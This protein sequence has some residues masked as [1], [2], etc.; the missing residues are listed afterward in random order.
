MLSFNKKLQQ[1]LAAT[2][3][4]M[5]TFA[6]LLSAPPAYAANDDDPPLLSLWRGGTLN[7]DFRY[8]L[9][10]AGVGYGPSMMGG[11]LTAGIAA[12]AGSMF[13]NPAN[14]G[15]LTSRSFL[16]DS[17][18][19]YGTWTTSSI[20]NNI[21]SSFND[22]LTTETDNFIRDP[23]NFILS[24]SP[25]I[26]PT[27]LNSI[28]AGIGGGFT[29]FAVAW[30]VYENIVL[31]I[32]L[33]QPADIRFRLQSSGLSTKIR[34]TQG[35]DD[36]TVRF[37]ILMNISSL[38]D[39]RFQ[40]QTF[41]LGLGS[42]VYSGEYGEVAAGAS[43]NRYLVDHSRVLSTDLSGFVVIGGADERFFNNPADPNLNF[44]AGETNEFV[45]QASGDFRDTRNGFQLAASWRTP[46]FADFSFS[47]NH[48]PEFVL[49][50]PNS[51]SRAFL[52]VFIVGQDVLSGDLELELDSLQ[53]NKPNL[54]TERDISDL[55][56]NS[57]LRLP[58]A[59]K[60][61]TDLKAGPHT[62]VFNYI[63][64]T[65][66][67]R[68]AFGDDIIGKSTGSGL[69]FG[70]N[71]VFNDKLR[72]WG[73][74]LIPVRL[75]YLDIDGLLFQAFG[76]YSNYRNPNYSFGATVM[77]S[78][79]LSESTDDGFRDLF[80]NPIPTAFSMGR[81]YTIFDDVTIGMN[82]AA[83]PDLLFRASVGYRF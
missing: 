54:S 39:F 51:F 26:R 62:F 75:L 3:L 18:L 67:L 64:Y 36:V 35:T 37:D 69:G 61:G 76:R 21:L 57:R 68:L 43:L 14:L 49:N 65:T 32:G 83:F 25:T 73:W 82:I 79:A 45:M 2:C 1:G 6:M 30:P 70:A 29:S 58:S 42:V 55:I 33:T 5:L 48:M 4:L 15:F 78:G 7:I 71:F 47:Y 53:A 46:W 72:G 66:P 28:R 56:S 31:G 24:S 59:L 44:A 11:V 12:N 13:T 16:F 80:D 8:N 19:G 41:T 40:M 9:N 23:D 38:L 34:E 17:Q 63:A 60:L 10:A 20:E 77:L 52:P 50:D 22:E 81:W 74:A 27:E